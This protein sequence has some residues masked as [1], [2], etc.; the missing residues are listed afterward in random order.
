MLWL[1]TYRA[2]IRMSNQAVIDSWFE[3]WQKTLTDH[4]L[5]D[6]PSQV[7]KRS[8]K[9]TALTSIKHLYNDNT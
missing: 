7:I 3:F 4:G 6:K 9:Y 5:H 8:P 2:R 1:S